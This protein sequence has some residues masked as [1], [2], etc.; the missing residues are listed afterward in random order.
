MERQRSIPREASLKCRYPGSTLRDLGPRSGA[1]ILHFKAAPRDSANP[2]QNQG[3]RAVLVKPLC[4]S[5]GILGILLKCGLIQQA[6]TGG[7]ETLRF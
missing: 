7:A 4:V 2:F 3:V 1:G 6:G 5:P